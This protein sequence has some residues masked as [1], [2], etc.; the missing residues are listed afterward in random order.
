[1]KK[2]IIS[3]I[4]SVHQFVSAKLF[5][6][7]F[8]LGIVAFGS[9][10]TVKAG[11]TWTVDPSYDSSGCIADNLRCQNLKDAV[12]AAVSGDKIK[13]VAGRWDAQNDIVIENKDLIIEGAGV[14]QVRPHPLGGT[15]IDLT[16]GT[17][18]TGY[19]ICPTCSELPVLGRVFT[20]RNSTVTISNWKSPAA[21]AKAAEVARLTRRAAV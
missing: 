12:R 14:P 10:A 11:N 21:T 1:M 4:N 18:I 7:A 9:V 20:I 8:V 6:A 2:P 15:F 5:A 17:M 19:Q 13:I 3:P 16:T